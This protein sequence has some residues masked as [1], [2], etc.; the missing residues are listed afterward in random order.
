MVESSTVVAL[1]DWAKS[2]L[3]TVVTVLGAAGFSF[4]TTAQK[5]QTIQN[6]KV[7]QS[8]IDSIQNERIQELM[9]DNN[10][11]LVL[12]CIKDSSDR[13]VQ[14]ILKCDERTRNNNNLRQPR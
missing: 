1:L 5:I 3:L 4:T 8:K 11:L 13:L 14:S 7:S 10:N 6:D 9:M 12:R 2:N